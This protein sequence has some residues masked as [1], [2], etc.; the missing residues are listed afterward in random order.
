VLGFADSKLI[1]KEVDIVFLIYDCIHDF[2]VILYQFFFCV[3][4]DMYNFNS[5]I[6]VFDNNPTVVR[7]ML[8]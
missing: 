3:L 6:K 1:F 7:K 2:V 4:P 5:F 8:F